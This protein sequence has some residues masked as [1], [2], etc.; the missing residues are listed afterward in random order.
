[1]KTSRRAY[2]G[3]E[4]REFDVYD[5]YALPAGARFEGP[6]IVEET[7]STAVIEDDSSVTVGESGSLIIEIE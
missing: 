4:F 2:A 6:A 7:E 1:L 5:R 3:D